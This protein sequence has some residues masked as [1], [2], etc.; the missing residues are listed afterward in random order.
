M[1]KGLRFQKRLRIL[2]GVRAN[3]SKSGVSASFG[4]KGANVNVGRDGITTNAGIPGTGLSYRQK[5]SGKNRSAWIGVVAL[6]AGLAFAGWQNRE[7][8]ADWLAPAAPSPVVMASPPPPAP[9]PPAPDKVVTDSTTRK[10]TTIGAQRARLLKPGGTIYV[11]RAGSVLRETQKASGAALKK[12]A[13]G[14]AV[15][16]VAMDGAWTQV[17]DGDTTGWMRTSVLGPKP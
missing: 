12:L 7:K 9:A 6:L 11:R 13:K 1:L 8:I 16:V 15:T 5:M 2:P 14:S 10:P 4:P 17:K 3:L